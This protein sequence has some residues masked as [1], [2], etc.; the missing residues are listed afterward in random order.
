MTTQPTLTT[1][2]SPFEKWEG[3]RERK[4]ATFAKEGVWTSEIKRF[5]KGADHAVIYF[6]RL[7][8]APGYLSDAALVTLKMVKRGRSGEKTFLKEFAGFIR[9]GFQDR[10][11]SGGSRYVTYSREGSN[12]YRPRSGATLLH[13]MMMGDHATTCFRALATG[14][15]VEFNMRLDYHTSPIM[16]ERGLHG[17][18]LTVTARKGNSVQEFVLDSQVSLH[19]SARF[20]FGTEGQ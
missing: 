11:E 4:S 9:T 12:L 18:V 16:A 8:D 2:L 13:S 19:N 15:V 5:A 14:S 17:D 10:I 6:D 1:A 3:L 20:G 7:E